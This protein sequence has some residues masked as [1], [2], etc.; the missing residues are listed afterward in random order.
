[1]LQAVQEMPS[2]QAAPMIALIAQHIPTLAALPSSGPQAAFGEVLASCLTAVRVEVV[3]APTLATAAAALLTTSLSPVLRP[4]LLQ[5]GDST[6][7]ASASQCGTHSPAAEEGAS[8]S[9]AAQLAERALAP[10]LNFKAQRAQQASVGAGNGLKKDVEG[11]EQLVG[12]LLRL[13]RG[14]VGLYGQCAATQLQIEPL[15]GQAT[16]LSAHRPSQQHETGQ[17]PPLT[18]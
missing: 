13:Y 18:V 17:P 7:A 10:G 4:V 15:P 1:M 16:G 11:P 2:G 14:A 5:I 9:A 3:S 6:S 8:H 12:C